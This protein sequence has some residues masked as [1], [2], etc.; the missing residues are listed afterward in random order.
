MT[1]NLE[2]EMWAPLVQKAYAKLHGSFDSLHQGS[3]ANALVCPT[4]LYK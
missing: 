3:I 2:N 4:L 1:L